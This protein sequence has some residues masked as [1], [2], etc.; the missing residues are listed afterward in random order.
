MAGALIGAA[1]S[2]PDYWSRSGLNPTFEPR[3]AQELD[4]AHYDGLVKTL[5]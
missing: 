4:N 2:E 3:Y 1:H 5:D